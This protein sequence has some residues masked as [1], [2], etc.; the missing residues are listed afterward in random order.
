MSAIIIFFQVNF[1]MIYKKCEHTKQAAATNR[2][3]KQILECLEI[4]MLISHY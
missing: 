2:S 1:I 4:R 3:A